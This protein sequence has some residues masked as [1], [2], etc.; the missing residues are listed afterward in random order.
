MDGIGLDDTCEND[1]LVEVRPW[2]DRKIYEEING[3]YIHCMHR[4]DHHHH[5]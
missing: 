4:G 2:Q 1:D 5:H 3:V